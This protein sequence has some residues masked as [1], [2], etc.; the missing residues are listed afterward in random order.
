MWANRRLHCGLALAVILAGGCSQSV[1]VTS[2]YGPGVRFSDTARTYAW[3]PGSEA[4]AGEG[5]PENPS[6]DKLIREFVDAHLARKGYEK[7]SADAKPDF[8]VDYVAARGTRPD[9]NDF[10]KPRYPVG[11]LAILALEPG[12]SKLI[13]KGTAE[14]RLNESAPPEEVRKRLDLVVGKVIDQA[15]TAKPKS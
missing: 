3:A 14:T 12:T 5:R 13:W 4:V 10:T 7:A 2:T 15:P 9:A 8:W 11:Q 6:A 1:D